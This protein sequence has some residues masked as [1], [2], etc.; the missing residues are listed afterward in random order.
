MIKMVLPMYT[1]T[2]MGW[3][4]WELYAHRFSVVFG[5]IEDSLTT[6]LW[7]PLIIV[8]EGYAMGLAPASNTIDT[9]YKI[10]VTK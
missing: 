9:F 2:D 5:L 7:F 8:F 3:I 6:F 4:A 1:Y 10:D